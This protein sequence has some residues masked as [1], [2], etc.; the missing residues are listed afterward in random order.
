MALFLTVVT[1]KYFK[2]ISCLLRVVYGNF[3]TNAVLID[4]GLPG[5]SGGQKAD[6]I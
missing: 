1:G 4:K 2:L 3:R 5:K 6:R